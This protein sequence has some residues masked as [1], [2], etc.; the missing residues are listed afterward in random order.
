MSRGIFPVAPPPGPLHIEEYS[1]LFND[2]YYP[3]SKGCNTIF[4]ANLDSTIK[5]KDIFEL[6][7]KI[8]GYSRVK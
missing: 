6:C 4:I 1:N 2:F 8:P 7:N 3:Q 5:E